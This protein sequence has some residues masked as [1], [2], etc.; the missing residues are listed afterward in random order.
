MQIIDK[1]LKIDLSHISD[2]LKIEFSDEC[3]RFFI[4]NDYFEHNEAQAQFNEGAIYQYKIYEEDKNLGKRETNWV[5]NYNNIQKGIFKPYSIRNGFEGVFSPNTFVGTLR[6][7]FIN[8]QRVAFY[9]IEVQSRKINYNSKSWK[10]DLG[11]LRSEYQLML[12]NIAEYSI[13]LILENNVP[14]LQSYESG[15]LE[16]DEK[17]SYQRFLFVRSLFKNMEFEETIQKVISNPSTIWINE[18]ELRDVRGIKRFTPQNIRELSSRSN[19][20]N[21]LHPIFGMNDIPLKISSYRKK[22]S[23]DTPENRF[24]K[25][26]LSTFLFFCE[27]IGDKLKSDKFQQES[28]E[29]SVIKERLENILNQS[30]F[31]D[32]N[33]PSTLKISSPVLQR[34]SGYRE[35]LKA[36]L[37]FNLT[38]QL[39]WKFDD[40]DNIFSG[41]KKDIASLYE[42][43]VFFVLFKMFITKFGKHQQAQAENWVKELIVSD[44]N[45][46][47]LTLRQGIKKAFQFNFNYGKRNL[48]IKFYYNRSFKGG[49][50]Y[51]QNKQSGSYTKNF[52]PDYTLSVWPSDMSEIQAE[53][54]ESIVHIHFDA[55]YKVEYFYKSVEFDNQSESSNE[56][57]FTIKE[58]DALKELEAEEE[59]G[60]FKDIDLY[61]MHAYKDAIRRS[62]GAYILY[63]G[64]S[65]AENVFKGYHEIIPGV[66][67]FALRP[68][69]EG[70]ALQNL[71]KFIAE[72]IENL[73][74]VISQRERIA[75]KKYE[76]IKNQPIKIGDADLIKIAHK[77]GLSESI[78]ETYVLV[79]FCKNKTHY[80]WI[81][82][83]NKYNIRYGEG[84]RINGKMAAANYLILYEAT[85]EGI[86]F[87]HDVVFELDVCNTKLI[88]KKELENLGYKDPNNQSYLLYDIKETIP[89]GDYRFSFEH[90]LDLR[91][92]LND[93]SER[94]LPFAITLA[95]LLRTRIKN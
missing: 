61:K 35:L 33:K 21:L 58:L 95:D 18:E 50:I 73:S 71:N 39:N 86:D 56:D 41:G 45:G 89:L 65:D 2:G 88:S 24:I 49:R 59:S 27:S 6:I 16:I 22:E 38:A 43:W 9:D 69:N 77:I 48:S 42:Y 91:A 13:E 80:E 47:G 51:G 78:D 76:I 10:N 67:A 68:N 4:S 25:H 87:K 8:D 31:K 54:S 85:A 1:I 94:Q 72:I 46:L 40:Q 26:V 23:I 75:K 11:Q 15:L 17:Q 30:F 57:D 66:G 28:K 84:Y 70:E 93:S 79:G 14:I 92:I 20:I 60:T 53:Q 82:V 90:I 7:P 29:V 34:R 74:D 36:W 44:K 12:E 32:I 62:G 81:T 37:R 52:R 83:K 19:R 64:S 3:G 63:P 5:V 55:K